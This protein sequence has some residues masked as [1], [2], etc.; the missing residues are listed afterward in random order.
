MARFIDDDE[1]NEQFQRTLT[2]AARGGADL[3][4]ALAVASRITPGDFG[5]WAAEWTAAA[6]KAQTE[7]HASQE[8]GDLVSA[9]RA[10]L[11]AAEYYRQTFF[12]ARTDLDDPTLHSAYAGHVAAFRA[13]LPLLACSTTPMDFER[14]GIAVH[15][16]LLRP[17][18]SDLPRPTVIAPAGYDSTAEAGYSVTAVSALERGMNCLVLEGP[19]QGG[20]LYTRRIPLRHDS[21]AVITPVID[22]LL[23]QEGVDPDAM[24]LFGRSFAGYLAPRAAAS[25]HRLA[26]LICDPAQYDFGAA[27]RVRL[28]EANWARLQSHDPTLDADLAPM[29]ADPG[30]RNGFE[31]RMV[32]HGVSTT[33]D[34]LRE[35]CRFSIAGIADRITCPTLALAGEGDF[36][37]TGQL[38][39]FADALTAPV[40]THEFTAAEG[41]GGHC[42]GLG[43]DRLDQFVY[44]WLTR[45]LADRQAPV[46]V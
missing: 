3:G 24:I 17:D 18:G 12:F 14:D 41:A 21:E 2:A 10:Y 23:A 28:G 9:R 33:S 31:W 35:L 29:L 26:A 39:T 27:I 32:A 42:E 25:E 45:T 40:T 30:A 15:G 19:G 11:R 38:A 43:Q 20:V 6:G 13:A 37:G 34:Y 7:A 8:A 4:E 1:L 44:G 16:Y 5:S 36:A 22:W 46:T